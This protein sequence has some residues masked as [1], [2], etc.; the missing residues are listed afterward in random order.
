MT[1][2]REAAAAA[3]PSEIQSANLRTTMFLEEQLELQPPRKG[4]LDER[5][6]DVWPPDDKQLSLGA[7]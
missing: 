2:T 5:P 1:S 4:R 6:P 3:L 7:T